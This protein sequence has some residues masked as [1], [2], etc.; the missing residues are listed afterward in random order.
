MEQRHRS[1]TGAAAAETTVDPSAVRTRCEQLWLRNY[2]GDRSYR[3]RLSVSRP[4]TPSGDGS[5]APN[6]G[7][8]TA[9]RRNEYEATYELGPGEVTTETGVLAPG[10]YDVTVVG[11]AGDRGGRGVKP[12]EETARCNV[13][14]HPSHTIVVEAGNG[15][16]S[17]TEGIVG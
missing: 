13:G 6:D 15:V 11:T 4:D 12:V 3:V 10:R 7:A 9:D 2:D 14:E 5:S 8:E 16:V 17:V 1:T